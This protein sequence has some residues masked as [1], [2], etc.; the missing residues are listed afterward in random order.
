MTQRICAD[1][2]MAKAFA[3]IVTLT[4]GP[5][6]VAAAAPGFDIP[7]QDPESVGRD[8]IAAAG[9]GPIESV[10]KMSDGSVVFRFQKPGTPSNPAKSV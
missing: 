5:R 1:P 4:I 2:E 9:L 10:T 6:R 8:L 3:S 7:P